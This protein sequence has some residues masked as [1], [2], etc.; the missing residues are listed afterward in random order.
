M[1]KELKS[2]T[3]N[4]LSQR[5]YVYFTNKYSICLN[6]FDPN[7]QRVKNSRYRHCWILR[8]DIQ[9]AGANG[10]NSTITREFSGLVRPEP[11]LRF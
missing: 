9:T 1:A 6:N 4:S 10:M 5:I 11:P 8:G 7:R 2:Q 3:K